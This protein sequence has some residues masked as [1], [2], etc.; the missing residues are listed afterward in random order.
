MMITRGRHSRFRWGPGE[1]FPKKNGE[2]RGGGGV[3]E[4]RGKEARCNQKERRG[5]GSW[6]IK[7]KVVL[8]ADDQS[9]CGHSRVQL[10]QTLDL[11]TKNVNLL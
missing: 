2:R 7:E 4:T 3:H 8:M 9:F 10:L 11:S 1:G 5:R 6:L